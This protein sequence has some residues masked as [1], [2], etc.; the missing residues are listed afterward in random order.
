M[1]QCRAE[2]TLMDRLR[3][4]A[5]RDFRVVCVVGLG[6]R[7]KCLGVVFHQPQL[8]AQGNRV[9]RRSKCRRTADIAACVGVRPGDNV[10]SGATTSSLPRAKMPGVVAAREL[11]NVAVGRCHDQAETWDS[12]L[13]ASAKPLMISATMSDANS[14]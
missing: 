7:E 10:Y 3:V 2:M 13:I 14:A 4:R 1:G 9:E 5:R 12:V 8:A 6:I 11:Q